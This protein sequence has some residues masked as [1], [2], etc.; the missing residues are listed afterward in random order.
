MRAS[1][2]EVLEHQAEIL[3]RFERL[4]DT[5]LASERIRIHGDYHLGQVL[6][7]GKDFVVIDFEGEPAR[8][9]GER[10]LKRSP[11][12]DVAGML[13]SFHYAVE[14]VLLGRAP[15]SA[16]RPE[17][18]ARLAPWGDAWVSWVSGAFLQSY[19]EEAANAGLLTV[20][21]AEIELLLDVHLLEK[22]LYEIGY[23]LN[24]RPDWIGVPLRGLLRVLRSG[25]ET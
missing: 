20:D 1:A 6:Y 24:N 19:L 16:L 3:G 10:R 17:D 9:L 2:G 4:R 13:R 7:T 5:P 14:S 15:G 25:S 23:E 22:A 11:L 12:V 8:S 18:T 21:R